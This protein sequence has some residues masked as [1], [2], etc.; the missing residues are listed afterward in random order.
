MNL[1]KLKV[2]II[3]GGISS[4]REVSLRSGRACFAALNR[5]GY[6]VSLLDLESGDQIMK[7]HRSEEIDVAFLCTHGE[8]GEDGKLQGILEWRKIP[9]TGSK[10]LASALCMNKFYARQVLKANQIE[11][12]NGGL[13]R[14]VNKDT[15]KFPVMLKPV[16]SGSSIG[17]QKI[18][19]RE[20][21]EHLMGKY[22]GASG[23]WLVEEFVAGRE[24]TVSLL[25]MKGELKVL[26]ILELKSK[27]D[28]YD[29]EAKY[30]KGMTEMIVPAPLDEALQKAVELTAIKT[31]RALGCIGFG[32]VDMIIS[33]ETNKPVVLE[34]NTLPG[35]TETSD[36]PASAKAAGIEFDE[37]VELMLKSVY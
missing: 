29:Y 16:E 33:K 36:L 21:L 23:E 35:M 14:D 25:Q 32:R 22:Q 20:E 19:S 15:L 18:K 6:N 27:N 13:L 37:L 31:F 11:I 4:E 7:L 8:Y 34:V 28:I 30:T 24:L 17:I 5:L 10:V 1:R 3:A 2:V 26:P 9:Y 12:S